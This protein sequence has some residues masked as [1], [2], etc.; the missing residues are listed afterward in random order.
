MAPQ[1]IALMVAG[2]T[3][4]AYGSY[5]EGKDKQAVDE[6]NARVAE[7]EG[8]GALQEAG[9][10]AEIQL[11]QDRAVRA[12][13]M[14]DIAGSGIS[15]GTFEDVLATSAANSRLNAAAILQGGTLARMRARS[16]AGL[17]RA[18]GQGAYE[19][20][21]LGAATTLATGYAKAGMDYQLSQKT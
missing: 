9:S 19:A 4:Q 8:Q 20:G 1:A 16:Q 2:T 13:Q 14:A 11:N 3:L 17:S 18:M 10:Q 6:Y 7:Q 5:K 12:R 21:L 15:G